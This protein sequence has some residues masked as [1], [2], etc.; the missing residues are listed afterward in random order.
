MR[1]GAAKL[2][3]LL[4]EPAADRVDCMLETLFDSRAAD[5]PTLFDRELDGPRR[6]GPRRD[7]GIKRVAIDMRDRQ[8]AEF[9]MADQ[10]RRAAG[11]AALGLL[12]SSFEGAAIT[13]QRAHG[14]SSG[15]HNHAAPRTPL[16]APWTGG[17]RG[18]ATRSEK[19][20]RAHKRG[21][22]S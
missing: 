19:M 17:R 9:G 21:T 8:G 13:A 18:V 7:G 4:A 2:D 12:G 14:A 22:C 15:G 5:P 10:P 11:G 6:D 16:D 3:R 1:Q 20:C